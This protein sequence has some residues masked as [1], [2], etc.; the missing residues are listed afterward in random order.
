MRRIAIIFQIEISSYED[1]SRES[2]LYR[3]LIENSSDDYTKAIC[4]ILLINHFERLKSE[5]LS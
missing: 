5:K 2:S 4:K 3:I 1:P